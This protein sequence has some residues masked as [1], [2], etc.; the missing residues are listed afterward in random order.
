[1]YVNAGTFEMSE[2]A[3][4]TGNNGGGVYVNGGGSSFNM[5][6]NA[7]ITGNNTTSNGGGVYV[8][9]GTVTLNGGEISGNKATNSSGGGIYV[10]NATFTMNGGTIGAANTARN[11]GGVFL[12]SSGSTFTMT[13]GTIGGAGT[14]ANA[15][16]LS[17]GGVFVNGGIFKMSGGEIIG[18]TSSVFG[19]DVY[20]FHSNDATLEMSG[21]AKITE[22]ALVAMNNN[23]KS[24]V[25]VTSNFT[26]SV[27]KLDLTS[28]SA[29]TLS[30]AKYDWSSSTVK[31]V[32]G[33]SGQTMTKAI[34]DRFTL[35]DFL[36][37]D[38][39]Q[40]QAVTSEY[41][42]YGTGSGETVQANF[43]LLVGN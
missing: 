42:L 4:I 10:I 24:K 7:A 32:E 8:D 22:L 12:A 41:R 40:S 15:A 9:N 33:L 34:L 30:N 19:K 39:S 27:T 5:S 17:G 25:N 2:N 1:V 14:A 35:G 11:G 21:A 29:N 23:T 16:T 28:S 3:S 38:G 31:V 20:L 37:N 18:N 13:G 43:G 26:G 6:G 36:T